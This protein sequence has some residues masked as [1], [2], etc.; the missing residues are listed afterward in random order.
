M[1]TPGPETEHR[2]KYKTMRV[3]RRVLDAMDALVKRVNAGLPH[4]AKTTRSKV[5]EAALGAYERELKAGGDVEDVE[6]E[7]VLTRPRKSAT[8][9]LSRS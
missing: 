1:E 6:F 3:E 4:T 2:D 9:G 5:L 7:P 8:R